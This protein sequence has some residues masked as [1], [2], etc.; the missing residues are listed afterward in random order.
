MELSKII[1]DAKTFV[2]GW[3]WYAITKVET[4]QRE[5][6][7]NGGAGWIW[8]D[9]KAEA[10]IEIGTEAE[11]CAVYHEVFHSAF[12]KSP[13]HD[14]GTD[15]KWGDAWADCFRYSHDPAFRSKIDKYRKMS[16][17]EAKKYGDWNHDKEYAYPCSLI[18][19][20]C[21][22]DN[23]KIKELWF[24]LCK[25]RSEAKSSILNGYF[26]YDIE[27]GVPITSAPSPTSS[28][29]LATSSGPASSTVAKS[30]GGQSQK[31]PP[32]KIL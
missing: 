31:N 14:G 16:Y 19:E 2:R 7:D 4:K 1:K 24:D 26:G 10:R 21:G 9:A 5:G 11:P 28:A 3:K 23:A 6:R 22:G 29:A 13:L 12:H 20:K 15:Q 30:S 27:A 17:E 18:V 32:R 25:K 8:D